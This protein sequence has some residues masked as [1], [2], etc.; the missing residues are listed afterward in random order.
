MYNNNCLFNVNDTIE[1]IIFKDLKLYIALHN[2]MV[3][4]FF[5]QLKSIAIALLYCI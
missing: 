2:L 1:K 4:S 5:K 3:N